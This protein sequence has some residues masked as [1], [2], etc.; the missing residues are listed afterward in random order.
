MDADFEETA[1]E[2][3]WE[4]GPSRASHFETLLDADFKE[5]PRH[6]GLAALTSLLSGHFALKTHRL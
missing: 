6:L 3:V 2:A 5:T 1:A 4:A